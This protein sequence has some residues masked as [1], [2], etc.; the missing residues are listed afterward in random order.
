MS[1]RGAGGRRAGDWGRGGVTK[2]GR[3]KQAATLHCR[4]TGRAQTGAA[5]PKLHGACR[6]PN[7][8]ASGGERSQRGTGGGDVN[9]SVGRKRIE[10]RIGGHRHGDGRPGHHPR[11]QV[12]AGR[13]DRPRIPAGPVAARP[14]RVTPTAGSI[15]AAVEQATPAGGDQRQAHQG[16]EGET[17][18]GRIPFRREGTAWWGASQGR[19]TLAPGGM[20]TGRSRTSRGR[21]RL[22]PIEGGRGDR[23]R[24]QEPECG[25][26]PTRDASRAGTIRTLFAGGQD[27]IEDK[28]AML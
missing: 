16:Q 20:G 11:R 25:L 19:G 7:P 13:I 15:T 9:E 10:R 8:Q 12:A 27:G 5:E 3:P 17:F 26:Q 18:H 2:A 4:R 6:E 28:P 24:G 14:S 23:H 21:S 1:M 22:R